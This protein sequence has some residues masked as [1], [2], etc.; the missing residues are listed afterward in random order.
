MPITFDTNNQANDQWWAG[1]STLDAQIMYQ[2]DENWMVRVQGKNLTDST[3]QK[4]VGYNQELN[5]S[6]LENGRGIFFGVGATF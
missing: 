4:V 1:M 3:P 5:Y 6:A 2:I